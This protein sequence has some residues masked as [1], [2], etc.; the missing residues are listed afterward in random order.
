MST[1]ERLQLLEFKKKF[2]TPKEMEFLLNNPLPENTEA[3][4]R[5]FVNLSL[6]AALPLVVK[7][8]AKTDE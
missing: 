3:K 7:K 8:K 6:D 2:L 1:E 4:F 5:A